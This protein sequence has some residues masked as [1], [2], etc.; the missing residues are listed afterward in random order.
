MNHEQNNFVFFIYLSENYVCFIMQN[1]DCLSE[2][3]NKA[4]ENG[5]NQLKWR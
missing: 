5:N 4:G 1:N 3:V 2:H